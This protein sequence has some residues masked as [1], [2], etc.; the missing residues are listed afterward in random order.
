MSDDKAPDNLV[1]LDLARQQ[2]QHDLNEARLQRMRQAFEQALP[3]PGRK[4]AAGKK[5]SKKS[6]SPRKKK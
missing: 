1:D 6:K 4:P 5:K 3:L 2:R